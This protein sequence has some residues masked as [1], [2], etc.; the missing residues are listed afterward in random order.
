[1]TTQTTDD[2]LREA[3]REAN[4]ATKDLNKAIRE[5]RG[6]QADLLKDADVMV[7][8]AVAE[9]LDEMRG[10]TRRAMDSAVAKVAK[11]FGRLER[12]FLMGK[13]RKGHEETIEET[14]VRVLASRGLVTRDPA[15]AATCCDQPRDDDGFC[16]V[17]PLEHKVYVP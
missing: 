12:I 2:R 14:A 4:A 3:T 17:Q 6:L 8:A 10:E 15:N 11:E 5:A 16:I 9:K 1:M 13:K 7:R